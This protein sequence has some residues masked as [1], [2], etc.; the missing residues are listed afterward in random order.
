MKKNVLEIFEDSAA[1]YLNKI[2]VE[3][4]EKSY[5][6]QELW[7]LARKVGSGLLALGVR[8]QPMIVLTDRTVDSLVL[9][10]GILYSGNFYVPVDE[11]MPEERLNIFV[12][13]IKPAAIVS[14][15]KYAGKLQ[16]LNG[17]CGLIY[18]E[19]LEN[20]AA[21]EELEKIIDDTIDADPLYMVF[22]SGST[23]IP[24]GVIKTH[25][26]ILAF[27]QEFIRL[28]DFSEHDV[29]GNQAAFD[30]DV[31]AKDIYTSAFLGGTLCL[32]PKRYF[33]I[34]AKL[35]EF[36]NAHRVTTL[37]WAVSAVIYA[38]DARCFEAEIPSC[39]NKV[40]F[41]GEKLPVRVLNAW[42][43]KLP[44]AMYVNLYAPSEVTGN[45][46]YHIVEE[47]LTDDD[48]IPLGRTFPN[49]DVL[50]LNKDG[51]RIKEGELGE[52]YVRGAFLASGYYND[53]EKTKNAFIQ[54]PLQKDYIDI[55]YKTGDLAKM[56][57]GRLYYVSRID[58]QVKHMGHRIEMGEIESAGN[59]VAG[60]KKSCAFLDREND[61]LVLVVEGEGLE[62][63]KILGEL[64]KRLPKY[65]VPQRIFLTD[66]LP[67]NEHGKISKR[68]IKEKYEQGEF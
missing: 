55:V 61:K 33:M 11:T 5:T 13:S 44:D 37:I 42:R 30:F 2:A 46:L 28:F 56:Y 12:A 54:N 64:R 35:V 22:T 31:S 60:V 24:K 6:Y 1:K 41:S 50:I 51:K 40:L 25:R 19:L 26:S 49:M 53:S 59:R 48:E 36:L 68:T 57:N 7:M 47:N 17:V 63:R 39:V 8:K 58:D 18:E 43:E 14:K 67:Q 32:I 9:F 10:W 29:F 45:C 4:N 15:E 66:H 34:P 21:E 16:K 38:V 20:M 52:I 62:E 3:D 23:G 27:E 65:M